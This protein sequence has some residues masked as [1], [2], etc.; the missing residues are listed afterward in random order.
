MAGIGY[1]RP[2]RD[3]R[4]RAQ[5]R[6]PAPDS[7]AAGEGGHEGGG[8]RGG[9]EAGAGPGLPR[10]CPSCVRSD[11]VRAVQAVFLEGHRHVREDTGVGVER[12]AVT[13]EV[14]SRLAKALA[15]TPPTPSIQGRGCLGSLLVLVSI[16]T[17]LGGSL[18]GHWFDGITRKSP[19]PYPS[20]G[21][22][23]AAA[24][25]AEPGLFFLG[26]VSAAALVSAVVLFLRVSRDGKAYRARTEPGLA[27][28]ER[29][30]IQGWY[31]G[32][33]ARVH[34]EGERAALTLQEFRVRVWTAGG[35]GDLAAS[36]PAVDLTVGR[37]PD[38]SY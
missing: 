9:E 7:P 35:Y 4:T 1:N 27:A 34:F 12:R 31:C 24:S 6:S 13:R 14:V 23:E 16:G 19:P 30:W 22:N 11:E 17:F 28:A 20:P 5:T 36:N 26:V 38:G 21:W 10:V 25:G 2:E 37:R 32:R 18:A 15:P 8:G 29:L 3:A 33:C